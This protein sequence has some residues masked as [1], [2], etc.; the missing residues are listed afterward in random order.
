MRI[1]LTIDHWG[2]IGGS[3]RYATA[4]AAALISRGHTVEVLAGAS[5]GETLAGVRCTVVPAYS[6]PKAGPAEIEA[7]A[8]AARGIAS[9]VVL[10]LSIRSRA[11]LEVLYALGRPVV[12]FVQ[13]HTLFCPGLNKLHE[14][15]SN[16]EHALGRE[17]LK[18]YYLGKGCIGFKPV[19]HRQPWRD[20]F[21]GVWKHLRGV[22]LA[23]RAAATYVASEYMRTELVRAGF[24]RERVAVLPLF[25][26]SGTRPAGPEAL[27]ESLRARIEAAGAPM[28]LTP[29]R[30][31]LPDKGVDYLL[32]ALG[33]V[34]GPFVAVIAG[35]GPHEAWLKEKAVAEGLGERAIFTGW[36]GGQALEA[37]YAQ[38]SVVAFPSMWNEPF[39]L[40]G[41]EAMAHRVP[42]VAFRAGGVTEWLEDGVNGIGIPRGDTGA[43]A[44]AID[45]LLADP[46]RRR[47]L[48]EAGFRTVHERLT[49]EAHVAGLERLLERVQLGSAGAARERA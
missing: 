19:M 7:L 25:T 42:V 11:T 27:P 13:D 31:V 24:A 44:G 39:G 4:I 10:L 3:E 17:C 32:T 33:Q 26:D 9:D 1:L 2:L 8:R 12:R 5:A 21:G 36:L 16:C 38:A 6:E 23:R 41:L 18:R 48:G 49:R 34:K 29:A 14:D 40:V 28:V 15:Q 45:A 30:L 47:T 22:S 35:T 20:G 43:M 46:E 37:L